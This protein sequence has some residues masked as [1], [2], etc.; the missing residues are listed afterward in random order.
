MGHFNPYIDI[1]QVTYTPIATEPVDSAPAYV[2][3]VATTPDVVGIETVVFDVVFNRPMDEAIPP[4]IWFGATAPY[5]AFQ[6]IDNGNWVSPTVWQATFDVTSL[7][8]T[9]TLTVTVKNAIGTDGIEMVT[10]SRFSFIKDPASQISDQTPPNR[11]NV[12]A[13]GV[14]GD[15]SSATAIWTATDLDSSIIGYRYAIGSTQGER[16]IVNWVFTTNPMF[17]VSGLGLVANTEYWVSVQAQNAGGLWSETGTDSF[18]AG[19]QVPTQ[20][21]AFKTTTATSDMLRATL[22]LSTLMFLMVQTVRQLRQK[23]R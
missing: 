13:E 18:V 17:N 1:G 20:V 16:D 19:I 8:P 12:T 10:D 9:G 15:P 2:H 22:F 6:V 14:S 3:Q 11:P 21:G 23:R 7:V 4:G 5:T